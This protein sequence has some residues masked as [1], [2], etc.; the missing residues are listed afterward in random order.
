MYRCCYAIVGVGLETCPSLV[1][2]LNT[3]LSPVAVAGGTCLNPVASKETWPNPVAL[4]ETWLNPVAWLETCPSPV[5]A[6]DGMA[7]ILSVIFG[8]EKEARIL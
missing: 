4:E 2:W 3:C 1:A 6:A 7:S 5:A 8:Q